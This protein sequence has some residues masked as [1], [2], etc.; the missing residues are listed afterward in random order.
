DNSSGFNGLPGGDRY[1]GFSG[2]TLSGTFWSS[3]EDYADYAWIRV[4]GFDFA[5]GPSR[6]TLFKQSGLSVRCLRD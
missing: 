4:L 5:N 1:D 3:S 2:I 6:F